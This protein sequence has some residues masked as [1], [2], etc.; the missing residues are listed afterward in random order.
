MEALRQ[1]LTPLFSR[2]Q[3]QWIKQENAGPS[4]ARNHAVKIAR[5]SNLLFM[6]DDNY[7]YPDELERFAA[8]SARGY[9][10]LSCII[11]L[12]PDSVKTEAPTAYLPERSSKEKSRPVGWTPL[13]NA[14]LLSIFFNKLG[15]T[16]SLIRREVFEKLGGFQGNREMVFEDF[17][18]LTRA[19]IAGYKIDVLPEVLMLYRRQD[20]SRSMGH[21][22]FNSH[23]DSLW[24]IAQ[25]LPPALRA[26]LLVIRNSWY[27]RHCN[28]RDD[29]P[30]NQ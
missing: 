26:L 23:V 5:G 15:E 27:E 24:P 19:V 16:N 7:A 20:T 13:G 17:E 4:V 9:D 25:L 3:W 22:I 29:K 10:I 2:R 14:L 1:E 18:F 11:G 12:H 21:T 6:D 28:R 8:A 30:L